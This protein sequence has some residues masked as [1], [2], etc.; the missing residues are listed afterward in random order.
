[1]HR[2]SVFIW[3][4]LICLQWS[5]PYDNLSKFWPLV[6]SVVR[7]E[8]SSLDRSKRQTQINAYVQF[9]FTTAFCR[10]MRYFFRMIRTYEATNVSQKFFN[11]SFGNETGTEIWENG[12]KFNFAG[13]KSQIHQAFDLIDMNWTDFNRY[14][15][16]QTMSEAI[17]TPPNMIVDGMKTVIRIAVDVACPK[18]YREG[19]LWLILNGASLI[20]DQHHYFVMAAQVLETLEIILK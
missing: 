13:S 11:Y 7:E 3:W 10:T 15:L 9:D 6:R 18:G 8:G 5:W 14:D 4:L 12:G 16:G 2:I 17:F 19:I 20:I 1:M